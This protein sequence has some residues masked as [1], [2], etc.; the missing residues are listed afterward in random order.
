MNE[1]IVIDVFS[2]NHTYDRLKMI[3]ADENIEEGKLNES[4]V[5]SEK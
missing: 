1:M 4:V 3:E 5:V 2:P